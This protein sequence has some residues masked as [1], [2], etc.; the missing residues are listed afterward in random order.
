MNTEPEIT[1]PEEPKQKRVIRRRQFRK[2]P[3]PEKHQPVADY[4]HGLAAPAVCP[5][6]CRLERCVITHAD[7]CGHP[8]N[9]GLQYI[10]ASNPET[11][12]RFEEAKK[13]LGYQKVDNLYDQKT[14]NYLSE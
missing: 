11:L 4:L 12:A 14:G 13:R 5:S 1:G 7:R 6:G 8:G 10:D 3:L 2:R 9:G